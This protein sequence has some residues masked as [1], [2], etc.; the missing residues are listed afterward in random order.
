MTAPSRPR[1][2]RKPSSAPSATVSSTHPKAGGTV[3]RPRKSL[4]PDGGD[5][6]IHGLLTAAVEE[7]AQLLDCSVSTVKSQ[8][9][10][11]LA[12][13]RVDPSLEPVND[14]GSRS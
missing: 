5:G 12:K 13:L 2:A 8:S 10:R 7:T 4:D 11:A 6:L 9:A 1:R 14:E 3:R